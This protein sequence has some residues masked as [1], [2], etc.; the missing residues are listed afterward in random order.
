MIGLKRNVNGSVRPVVRCR[1]TPE[2]EFD[3]ISGYRE[4]G[5]AFGKQGSEKTTT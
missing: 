3:D 5:A 1:Q 2:V 4:I